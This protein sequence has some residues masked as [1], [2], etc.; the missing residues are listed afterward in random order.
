MD[1]K[2]YPAATIGLVACLQYSS[3][4]LGALPANCF[5]S[6]LDYS[7]YLRYGVDQAPEKLDG[8]FIDALI[9]KHG[10]AVVRKR[11]NNGTLG[12]AQK[13]MVTIDLRETPNASAGK[14]YLD[15]SGSTTASGAI[16][17]IWAP[18][19]DPDANTRESPKLAVNLGSRRN[20]TVGVLDPVCRTLASKTISVPEK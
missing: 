4:V 19:G 9:A 17:F 13:K 20:V 6:D 11:L 18:R 5:Q 8:T 14:L 12:P 7:I 3:A 16:E 2:K 1:I 10:E 15:A